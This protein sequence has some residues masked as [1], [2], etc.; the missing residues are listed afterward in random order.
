MLICPKIPAILIEISIIASKHLRYI[1][2][3]KTITY[4]IQAFEVDILDI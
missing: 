4:F 3:I 1:L 2:T